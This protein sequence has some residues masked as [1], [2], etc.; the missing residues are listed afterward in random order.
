[1][2]SDPENGGCKGGG[3]DIA[4]QIEVEA[5]IDTAMSFTKTYQTPQREKVYSNWESM[6]LAYQSLGVVYGDLGTSPVNV[7]SAT[8]FTNL[9][10]DDLLGTLSL[11]IWT[12]TSLVLVKYVFIVL[13]ANDHGEGGTFAIY[14]YICRHIHFNTKFTIHNTKLQPDSAM[15][16]YT[17]GG[18]SPLSTRAK[19]FL[20]RSS[21]AQNFL[22][23]IVLLGTCMVIGDG[24]LT[25]ATCALQGIQSRSSKITQDHVVWIS[26]VLLVALFVFQRCGTS[27]VSFLFSPIMLIW[28]AT[29]VSIG[30]YNIF[31]YDPSILKAVSPHYIVKFFMANGKTAWDL[32]GAVFLSIT[33]AE[34]MFTD[35]GHFNKRAIQLGFSLVVYPSLIVTYAGET[36]YLVK[37]PENITDA[38]YSSLPNP[39][40]WPM[41]VISTL[42]AVVASQSMISAC[43][44]IVKQS[45]ALGCFPRVNIIH[46][47]SNHQGQVYSPEINTILLILTV[48]LVVGFKGGVELANAYGVV[49]IWVM[50]ITTFLTSLV[51]LVIW[52]TNV[53]AVLGFLVPYVLM[54]GAFMTSLLRKIPQGGWVPFAISVLFMTVMMSWTYGRSKKTTYEAE[55]KMSVTE[56]D[57]ALSSIYRTPGVCLF[58]TDLVHGLPPIIRRYIHH[59]NSVREIMVVVT[60]RTLPIKTVSAEERLHVGKLG[61]NGVYQCLIQFGYKDAED[62]DGAKY[63]DHIAAKLLELTDD[64]SEKHKIRSSMQKGIEFVTGRTILKA[65]KKSDMLSRFTIDYMYRFLQKNSMPAF[66]TVR[67]PSNATLQVGMLYEI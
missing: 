42:A 36:A 44:S 64:N 30:V 61:R 20:E 1:M 29:N 57:E 34:A 18:H 7:F 37:H 60:I 39:V 35:L 8:S 4:R 55:N 13:H 5:D 3:G 53:V 22:T 25:P 43:F 58:F 46:T 28:F 51:M 26:V 31:K 2:N 41:F 59:M 21:S 66:S 15:A 52:K 16:Y 12:L 67:T 33:G 19:N 38:Y 49:V 45:L 23:V 62:I 6:V 32:L 48:A 17:G 14:S 47:S 9:S 24:A 63:T 50:M 65:N 54:E 11:I 10:E 40:Y 56:L 27:K